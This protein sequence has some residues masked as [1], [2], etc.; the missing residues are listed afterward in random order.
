V[1]PSKAAVTAFGP[2]GAALCG[3]NGSARWAQPEVVQVQRP[4]LRGVPF[5]VVGHRLDDDQGRSYFSMRLVRKM[6]RSTLTRSRAGTGTCPYGVGGRGSHR[7]VGPHTLAGRRRNQ[8]KKS[9]SSG[10]IRRPRGRDFCSCEVELEIDGRQQVRERGRGPGRQP[11]DRKQCAPTTAGNRPARASQ[12]GGPSAAGNFLPATP[13]R[14]RRAFGRPNSLPPCRPL[15]PV[16]TRAA[17]RIAW[18]AWPP[19]VEARFGR[20]DPRP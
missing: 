20:P 7:I 15:E 18:G 10:Q 9:A 17:S 6:E 2:P 13:P 5:E 16:M 3:S 12:L 8:K 11:R 1:A 4:G 14:V 19:P